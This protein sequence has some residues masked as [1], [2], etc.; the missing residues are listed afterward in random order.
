M[1]PAGLSKP[2]DPEEI[3]LLDDDQKMNYRKWIGK[4]EASLKAFKERHKKGVRTIYS[5]NDAQKM[6]EGT[7]HMLEDNEATIVM[8]INKANAQSPG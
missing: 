2:L 6:L 8:N 3:A 5:I 7:Y 4:Y 1:P